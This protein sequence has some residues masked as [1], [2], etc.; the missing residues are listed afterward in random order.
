MANDRDV[1]E[2]SFF[3]PAA[4]YGELTTE[5]AA[6]VNGMTICGSC[7]VGAFTYAGARTIATHAKIGRYCSI[8]E[9]VVIGPGRRPQQFLTLHPIATDPSGIACGLSGVDLYQRNQLTHYSKIQHGAK[10]TV[11]GN[12]VF[13]GVKAY[14][15]AEVH[16][17]DGAV[18]GAG[19]IV[20][21][22]VEPF[23]VVAGAPARVIR[24]R[25][26]EDLRERIL[27]TPWWNYD[28]SAMPMRDFSDPEAFMD[29]LEQEVTSG[30][31]KPM[32]FRIRALDPWVP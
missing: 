23:A 3:N 29:I 11:I 28:L 19:A 31:V 30:K 10:P 4:L 12:D 9:D 25:F 26:P 24:H 21:K 1:V 2:P 7:F 18:I 8:S 32:E 17:G 6:Q 14:V 16:V 15:G 27:R 5:E 22:N 20:T 13:I